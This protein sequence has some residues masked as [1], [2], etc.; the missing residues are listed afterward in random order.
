MNHAKRLGIF[1]KPPVPGAVKTR[2]SPPLS[3]EEA[4]DLYKAFLQ[5]TFRRLG[6]VKGSRTTVF[7][8]EGDVSGLTPLLPEKSA[9]E[10]QRGEDL[11]SRM[12]AAFDR[13]LHGAARAVIVG[14]DS[15]DLPIQYVRR[16][17][18]KLKH[19]D[20]VLGPAT[21]GGYYLVGLRAPADGLFDGVNWSGPD[22][23]ARTL[24]NIEA[25]GRSLAMLPMWYD[26]DD[27]ASL[28]IL[29]AMVSARR[30]EGRD[31]LH[32]TESVLERLRV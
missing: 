31:R 27:E 6:R 30:L 16:A 26:V 21:D 22:V 10:T 13:L 19:K 2:L 29:S 25:A 23:L 17:F 32:A 7:H 12:A 15:P 20:V 3:P 9:L 4:C 11:G 1:V 14:S 5:D 24:T 8:T 18:Q 28:R